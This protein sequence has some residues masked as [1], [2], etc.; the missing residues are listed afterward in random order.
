MTTIDASLAPAQAAAAPVVELDGVARTYPGAPPVEALRPCDLVIRAGEYVGIM[1]RSGSGK[2]TLLNV[3]GLLDEPTSGVYRLDGH[4]TGGL[5]EAKRSGLRAHR[6]GF[7]FQSFH[8]IGYRSAVENVE[9]GLLYQKVRPRQRRQRAI[10]VLERVGLA[11]RMWALPSELSGG[12]RQRVALA[13]AVVRRPALVLC[14]EP[15]GNLDSATSTDVLA[16]LGELHAEGLTIAVI[17]HDPDVAG[18]AERI[19]DIHDGTLTERSLTNV[20]PA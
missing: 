17:T 11:P 6:I 19:I 5:S 1:G 12:E 20:A 7:V 13:R 15:T 9:A 3:L 2:S 10:E 8:L 16:L 14:D 18:H 4:P